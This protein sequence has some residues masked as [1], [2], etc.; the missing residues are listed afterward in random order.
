MKTFS[1]VSETADFWVAEPA[2]GVHILHVLRDIVEANSRQRRPC[3][4]RFNDILLRVEV[5]STVEE[6]CNKY[7]G[8]HKDKLH[9]ERNTSKQT[10]DG[11][12]YTHRINNDLC[13]VLCT[14]VKRKSDEDTV[15]VAVLY[16]TGVESLRLVNFGE[17]VKGTD[18]EL[19]V[20]WASVAIDTPVWNEGREGELVAYHFAGLN[21]Y[22]SPLGWADGRTSHTNLHENSPSA[23]VILEQVRLRKPE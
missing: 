13:R 23:K 3:E 2:P 7:F 18:P 14:D 11:R 16:P 12:V 21:V 4:F 10:V 1:V 19:D 17:L 8:S 5:D 15:A 20:N 6:V 22:G 9:N